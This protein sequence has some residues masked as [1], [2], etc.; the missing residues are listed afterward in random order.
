MLELNIILV[1]I[2]IYQKEQETNT[3]E[4]P[5]GTPD[6][7]RSYQYVPLADTDLLDELNL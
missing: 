7:T 2:N 6:L 5:W 3:A 4:L 1:I